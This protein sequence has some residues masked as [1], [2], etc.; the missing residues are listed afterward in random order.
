MKFLI[1]VSIIFFCLSGSAQKKETFYDF[2]WKPCEATEARFYSTIE[3]KDSGWLRKD[4]FLSTRKLQ[5]QI[6][7]EDEA[8]KVPN[9]TELYFH[10]NG[11][12]SITGQMIH[13]K[14][15]GVC[16]R[17]YSN[18]VMADSADY[19]NGIPVGS[20]FMWHSNGYPSDSI[21]HVND[22]IDVHIGWFDDGAT[23][24]AGYLLRGKLTGKWKYFYH[25]GEV[26]A[27]EVYHNGKT[28]SEEFFN[29][30]GT[31]QTDTSKVNT[32]A[33]FANVGIEGWK[34]YLLKK[35]Y[36]PHGLQFSNGN[37]ATVGVEFTI[38]EEGKIEDAEVVTPFHPEFD[39]IALDVIRN[40]PPWK[41]AI[42]HNRKIKVRH[43]Q[44]VTFQQDD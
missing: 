24:F 36:W 44:P 3:K 14:Q 2:Y 33:S 9:G 20:R 1:A 27:A 18:G 6:L 4:Y 21:G 43:R 7:Y 5:M 41:P 31:P 22:S 28:V 30:D 35:L 34:K 40:S 12:P 19:H 8:C 26:A 25:N 17:Y 11:Y 13:G 38:T 32:E 39:K 23:S 10:A 15:E 29:E 42:A 37:M 16:V